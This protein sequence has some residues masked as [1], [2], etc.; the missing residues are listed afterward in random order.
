MSCVRS[1]PAIW[2]A[3]IGLLA[4]VKVSEAGA[5]RDCLD[6]SDYY[7]HIAVAYAGHVHSLAYAAPILF[8]GGRTW[9]DDAAALYLFDLT[10]PARPVQ[11]A[12]VPL[13]SYPSYWIEGILPD[14]AMLF[15]TTSDFGLITLDISDPTA[16]QILADLPIGFAGE[17]QKSDDLLVISGGQPGVALVNVADPAIPVLLGSLST[18][19]ALGIAVRDTLLY[20]ADGRGGTEAISIADPTAPV[21]LHI[22]QDWYPTHDVELFGDLAVI[23]QDQAGIRAVDVSNPAGWQR[24]IPTTPTAPVGTF[25]RQG[26]RLLTASFDY[27]DTL[28]SIYDL[29]TPVA[30]QLLAQYPAP[31]ASEAVFADS[32]LVSFRWKAV[33]LD[34]QVAPVP[35]PVLG[36]LALPSERWEAASLKDGLLYLAASQG[37]HVVDVANPALPA[38]RTTVDLGGACRGLVIAGALAYVAVS[39]SGLHVLDVSDPD[40]VLEIGSAVLPTYLGALALQ[41][42]VCAIAEH[43][44]TVHLYDISRPTAPQHL[45]SI[46]IDG[47]ISDLAFHSGGTLGLATESGTIFVDCSEPET[48]SIIGSYLRPWPDYGLDIV[49]D[50]AYVLNDLA[51]L[52]ILDI[53]NPS[54]P[55]LVGWAGIPDKGRDIAVSNNRAY[56]SCLYEG[57]QILDVSTPASPKYMGCL[58][59][60]YTYSVWVGPDWF[61]VDSYN[62]VTF[63]YLPC[64]EVTS[65]PESETESG[66]GFSVTAYPIPSNPT[67]TLVL[68]V[69]HPQWIRVAVYDVSGRRCAALADHWYGIGEHR[70]VWNGEREHAG[71]V[72]SGVYFVRAQGDARTSTARIVVVE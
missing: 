57:V 30:P 56:I 3:I 10:D 24:L 11:L 22:T 59:Q 12:L 50:L 45:S 71:Q 61:C 7:R 26:E 47:L 38:L 49:G 60:R 29:T 8:A 44:D 4:F 67:V 16:P 31:Y 39:Q 6:Y 62:G 14:G 37:L 33:C 28:M 65:V 34:Q 19:N 9:N 69:E 18:V 36:S 53:G 15:I 70:L 46:S 48:P 41:G 54:Q 32:L 52:A 43:R 20:V 13:S 40:N 1:C 58:D 2:L 55:Q 17:M 21:R 68:A 27:Y 63:G 35:A 51:G 64:G 72:A 66:V 25:S 23:A 42:D 5:G